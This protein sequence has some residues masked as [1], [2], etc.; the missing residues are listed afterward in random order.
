M[1]QKGRLRG[2]MVVCP[3]HIVC[4]THWSCSQKLGY[5]PPGD[6]LLEL[7]TNHVCLLLLE[8]WLCTGPAALH[9]QRR[10][11]L[12]MAVKTAHAAGRGRRGTKV[13]LVSLA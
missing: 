6:L 8:R 10:E 13:L 12:G 11:V 9:L 5:R 2:C 7:K 1:G 3:I 4:G